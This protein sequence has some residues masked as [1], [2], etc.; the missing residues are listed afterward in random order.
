M[1]E[2]ASEAPNETLELMNIFLQR[3]GNK[4]LHYANYLHYAEDKAKIR[5]RESPHDRGVMAEGFFSRQA[6]VLQTLLNTFL[7]AVQSNEL[8]KPSQEDPYALQEEFNKAFGAINMII[9]EHKEIGSRLRRKGDPKR[10]EAQYRTKKYIPDGEELDPEI[11]DKI[12][13][14]SQELREVSHNLHRDVVELNNIKNGLDEIRAN[15][16]RGR[17]RIGGGGGELGR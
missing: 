8:P 9:S 13:A 7:N 16:F 5:R 6:D 12:A 11:V 2:P 10:L 3:Y 4:L 1:S 14:R 15:L 17:P